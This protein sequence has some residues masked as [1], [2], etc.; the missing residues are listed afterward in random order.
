MSFDQIISIVIWV[1]LVILGLHFVQRGLRRGWVKALMTTGNIALS[2]FL[3]CFLSRDFTTIARDY[4]YPVFI[5]ITD[6]FGLSLEEKLAD[7]DGI[8]MLLPLLVGM[9]VTPFLFLLFFNVLRFAFGIALSFVYRPSRRVVNEE[10][11]KVKV[12]RHVPLWSRLV[13]AGIGMVNAVLLL[14]VL[15]LPLSGYAFMVKHVSTAYFEDLK[16]SEYSREGTTPHE[17]IYFAV[18]DYVE[19]ITNNLILRA[20]YNTYGKPMFT[21]MTGT[22]YGEEEIGLENEATVACDLIRDF[23]DF[24]GSGSSGMSGQRIEKLRSIVQTL[25]GSVLMPEMMASLLSELCD[26]WAQGESLYGMDR[27]SFGELLDPSVDV[28]LGILATMDG[29]TLVADLNTLVDVLDMLLKHGIFDNLNDSD[30]MM[31]TMGKNPDL[32]SDLGKTFEKNEHLAPMSA[33]IK[34]LCV[35]VLAQSLDMENTELTGKLTD[36]INSN[37]DQPEK[38]SA[39]LSTIAQEFLEEQGVDAT[40]STEMTDEMAALII[41]EFEGR[42]DVTEQEVID[43]VMHYASGHMG[44]V[45]NP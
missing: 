10:G 27:P 37:M 2:A 39:E 8:L 33:E 4:I 7:F 16:T 24:A 23:A 12:K 35:R 19:P 44:N 21:H 15:M 28:L 34:R 40:I 22:V 6:L 13:G 45:G 38:L 30:K 29:H 17:V 20:T 1:T 9:I 43:F 3:A 25:D 42:T 32:I 14:G 31:D 11:E 18:Q 26:N 36:S 41:H 5:W